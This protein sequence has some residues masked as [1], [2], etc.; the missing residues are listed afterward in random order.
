MDLIGE[1]DS[2]FL[3]ELDDFQKHLVEFLEGNEIDTAFF[4]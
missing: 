4:T 3:E 2:A 1:E